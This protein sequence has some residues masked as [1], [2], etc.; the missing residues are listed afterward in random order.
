M[1]TRWH[2]LPYSEIWV[3]DTEYYPGLGYGNGGR[4]GDLI[5]P[6]CLVAIEMRTGRVVRLW[7]DELGSTPPYRLDAGALIVSYM[8]TAEFGFHLAAGWEEPAR[9]ID[10]YI[11]FRHLTNDASVKSADRPKGFHSLAGALRY[12]GEDA[13]DIVHK[14][15][16]RERIL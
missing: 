14:D 3:V 12:F 5:T 1:V 2:N 15:D 4:D 16:M 7:Q 10:A 6:L 9:S 13:I 11:E 8:A